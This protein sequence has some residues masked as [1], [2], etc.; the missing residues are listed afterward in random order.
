MLIILLTLNKSETNRKAAKFKVNDRVRVSKYKNILVMM[1]LKI[2]PNKYL[3]SILFWKQIFGCI[4][5][6]ILTE[7]NNC[8]FLLKRLVVE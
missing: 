7:K 3:L 5:L 4:I 6:K 2:D 1:A 8:E